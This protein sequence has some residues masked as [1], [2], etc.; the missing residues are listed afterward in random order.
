MLRATVTEL[1]IDDAGQGATQVLRPMLGVGLMT[2]DGDLWRRQ[3]AAE[4][5]EKYRATTRR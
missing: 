3:R 1:Y 2:T 4:H 5:V